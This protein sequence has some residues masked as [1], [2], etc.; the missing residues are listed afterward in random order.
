MWT[1]KQE[2]AYGII[3]L[4]RIRE[5]ASPSSSFL[6]PMLIMITGKS[7]ESGKGT[8]PCESF[9]LIN[10]NKGGTAIVAIDERGRRI[11]ERKML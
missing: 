6:L 9:L 7:Y 10:I 2:L 11:R 4:R 3:I 5:S 1:N 8:T